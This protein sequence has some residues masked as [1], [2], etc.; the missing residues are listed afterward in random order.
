MADINLSS[1]AKQVPG[2]R[3]PKLD[4]NVR[5]PW[6]FL[7]HT[8]GRG[9]PEKAAKTKKKSI[10]IAIAIY[11][12]SQNG[13]N[14]YKWGGPTYVMAH[15][16]T[17]HQIAPDNI[18]TEHCGGPHRQEYLSGTWINKCSPAAVARWNAHWGPRYKSP[19][20]LFPSK[21]PNTD[22]IGCEMIPIGSGIGGEPMRKGLLFTKAQHDAAIALAKD[23]GERHG[24][25]GGWAHTPRFV[26]HE[27][28]QLLDRQDKGGGWDP[29]F[30]RMKP[31]FD[32]D[33]VRA[34]L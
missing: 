19:Q 2:C 3:S 34:G 18:R 15:D 20:E 5:I 21:S 29:G 27:D 31:Y 33:Y 28:V 11:I 12:D 8:T 30:L 26:G 17:I 14:G 7:L 25:P 22:Y 16:G 10:D 1:L 32:F 9:V 6:G 4:G 24:F 13:S 23:V